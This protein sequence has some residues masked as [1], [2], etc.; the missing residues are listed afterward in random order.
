MKYDGFPPE[1]VIILIVSAMH[2]NNRK[3]KNR[4]EG[5]GDKK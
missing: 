4:D 1:W 3:S 5:N 2:R